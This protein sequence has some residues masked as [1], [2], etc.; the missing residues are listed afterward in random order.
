MSE[1]ITAADMTAAMKLRERD[2]RARR[3]ADSCVAMALEELR[4]EVPH[5]PRDCRQY[6][7]RV[8]Q[9]ATALLVS[10]IYL[11]DEEIRALREERDRLKDLYA[12][13]VRL[14]P[15]GPPIASITGQEVQS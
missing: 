10:G 14:M 4:D 9:F 13:A 5:D 6:A 2:M 1:R 11:G 15:I 8:A 7:A 3:M 12:E